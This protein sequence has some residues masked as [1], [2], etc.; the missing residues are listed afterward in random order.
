MSEL[1]EWVKAS[2]LVMKKSGPTSSLYNRVEAHL[3]V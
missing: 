1:L 2:L 3:T